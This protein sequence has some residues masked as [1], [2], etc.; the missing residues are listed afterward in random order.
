L[1]VSEQPIAVLLAGG[2]AQRMGGGDKALHKIGSKSIL[3]HIID[4]LSPQ[5]Q[6]ILLN[7]NGDPDRFQTQLT[8]IADTIPDH[9]GPLAGIL[10]ALDWVALHKPDHETVVSVPADSPFLPGDLVKRL[11]AA[12]TEAG[13]ALACA[14][15]GARSHP[16]FSLWP[17]ALRDNLRQALLVEGLRKMDTFLTRHGCA[18]AHWNDKPYDPFF[19]I[20]HVDDLAKAEKIWANINSE[21][22]LDR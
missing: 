18:F 10:A 2:L 3:D 19:N 12:R 6:M 5:C 16:V 7:A 17:V 21:K 9:A 14:H 4:R 11:H 15:S 20:N 8:V 1:T 13:A 22:L